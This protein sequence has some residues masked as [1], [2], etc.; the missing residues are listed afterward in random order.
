MLGDRG[1]ALGEEV[2]DVNSRS[3]EGS[4][5]VEI[6]L[7]G[8]LSDSTG[9]EASTGMVDKDSW[10][11][12]LAGFTQRNAGRRARLE[13]LDPEI[14]AQWQEADYPLRGVAYDPR[15]GRIEIMLG[16]Q[17]STEQHLTH[18]IENVTD[19]DI[20][21]PTEGGG[22]VLRVTHGDTQTLLHL[23]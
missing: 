17:G 10:P 14:G 6:C 3:M 21:E 23:E 9:S 5:R 13:V 12:L 19:L 2:S 7:A 16:H 18:S 11:A 4:P 15:D 20:A 1:N 8:H 22:R